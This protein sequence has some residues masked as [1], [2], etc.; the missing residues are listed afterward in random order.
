MNCRRSVK[1]WE[2]FEKSIMSLSVLLRVGKKVGFGGSV[3]VRVRGGYYDE[4]FF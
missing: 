2:S 4:G 3:L 1:N